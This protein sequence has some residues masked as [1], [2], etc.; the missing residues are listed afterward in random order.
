MHKVVHLLA[1]APAGGLESVVATLAREQQAQGIAVFV[2]PIVHGSPDEH[3]FVRGLVDE[4]QQ[5]APVVC[6]PRGY[7]SE[8]RAVARI[9]KTVR[10]DVLHSHGYRPDVVDAPVAR[11]LR[12][13]TVTTVHGFTGNSR[14][15]R[16]NEWLQVRAF[17]RFSAVVPVSEKLAADLARRGVPRDRIRLVRN[18]WAPATEFLERRE[19]RAEL[20][21]PEDGSVVGWVGRFSPEKAPEGALEALAGVADR[22]VRLA[23]IGEGGMKEELRSLASSLGVGDHVTWLGRI[24]HAARTLRAFDVLLL[25]SR[26]EGT[27]MVLLEAMAAEVPIVTTSVGGIPEFLTSREA[28]LTEFGDISALSAGIERILQEPEAA[29]DRAHTARLALDDRF[30]VRQWVE[31]YSSVYDSVIGK[32]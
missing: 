1:P 12:I 27:P 4:G 17:R 25:S 10:P 3:P 16:L 24:P 23:L 5:V 28:I 20:G 15:N 31:R 7:L 19:A 13:P 21:L 29:R 2:A 14:R 8:R 26:T 6:S 11:R 9:L 18:S 32:P 22:S 30:N